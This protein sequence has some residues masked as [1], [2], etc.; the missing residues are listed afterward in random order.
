MASSVQSTRTNSASLLGVPITLMD[1]QGVLAE[2]DRLVKARELSLI[3]TADAAAIVMAHD[4]P[5]FKEDLLKA[6]MITADGVGVVW[7]L[8][9][10][11]NAPVPK[12][13]GVELAQELV[14]TSADTGYRIF[15]LGAA[16][17][18]ADLAAEK[19]RLKFP[20]CNIV[21]VRH[22]Y[23]PADSDELVA[24]EIAELKP[25]IL[26][27]AMG[28]PRQERFILSTQHIIQAPV[29]IGVGGSLDVFSGK[30]KRAPV[31][32]QKAKLEWF[33]RLALNPK[34]YSKVKLLPRFIRLVMTNKS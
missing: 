34:K 7:A 23:F 32:F 26:F 11:G 28:M 21:G 30:T 12:V 3:V 29:A 13:S 4:D 27:V 31:F 22:G 24:H 10:K 18:V 2:I 17:G 25:D 14:R 15:F 19:L 9:K 1:M 20:G 8:E 16:P 5:K 33:W 6:K